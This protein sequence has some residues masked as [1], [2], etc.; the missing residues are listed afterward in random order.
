[1]SN[2]LTPRKF[3]VAIIGAGVAGLY[4]AYC[5]GISGLNS[6]IIDSLM[7]PG[8]QCS[9]LY[10]DK[11]IYGVPGFDNI[12]ALDFIDKLS[13]Q[14]LDFS[15]HIFLGYRVEHISKNQDGVF[16]IVTQHK[17]VFLTKNLI[18]ATGIGDM[19]P[20]VPS[21]IKGLSEIEKDSDF[22]QYYCMKMDL[23]KNKT[24]V[25]AGG[26]DSAADF[27]IDIAPIAKK[28]ILVHRRP[29]LT[30]QHIKTETLEKLSASG[31]LELR[32][33]RQIDEVGESFIKL[34]DD[35]LYVDHIV[36]CYGFL[37][38]AGLIKG[39]EDMGLKT[40]NNLINVN[41]NTMETSIKNCFAIGDV[42]KYPNKKKN[43][44]P[45][46]FEADRAVRI[47]KDHLL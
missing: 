41:I 38:K 3:D 17:D 10:P 47:I 13:K 27:A 11:M 32:L 8:G 16:E 14:S 24:V 7:Y 44:V 26:G 28:V 33:D 12:K 40:E 20:S 45:C 21:N 37:A 23:Y 36:F 25:I 42:A 1:M 43:I 18:I 2:T 9:V 46:F 34:N 39:L 6:C 15:D 19:K 35:T 4:A 31:K 5:C 22:V 30:C 29:K